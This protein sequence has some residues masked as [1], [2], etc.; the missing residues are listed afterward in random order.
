M[1][2]IS[3]LVKRLTKENRKLKT[4]QKELENKLKEKQEIAQSG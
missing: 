1:S 3:N 4:K 2:R